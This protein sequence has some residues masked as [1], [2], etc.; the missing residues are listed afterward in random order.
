VEDAMKKLLLVSVAAL[1]V[2]AAPALAQN[3]PAQKP[4]SSNA[5]AQ[6]VQG[7]QGAQGVEGKLDGMAADRKTLEPVEL[8]TLAK[9]P[10][11]ELDDRQK[12]AIQQALIEEHTEQKVPKDF[13]PAVGAALPVSM[14]LDVMPLE[15]GRKDPALK[16]FGYAKTHEDILVVDPMNKKIVAVLPRA[17]PNTAKGATPADWASTKGRELTGQAPLPAEGGPHPEPAGDAGDVSNGVVPNP[18]QQ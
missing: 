7:K 8:S 5:A 13:H 9:K 17:Y 12:Q 3:Q 14:K 18:K 4:A 1:A 2:T 10:P 16:Q 11:L 15:L 6:G